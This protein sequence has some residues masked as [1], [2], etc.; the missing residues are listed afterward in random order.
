MTYSKYAFYLNR[1]GRDAGFEDKL[2]SYCFRRGCANAIDGKASDA[3][4]D[5]VMRHNPF[6]GV[7]NEAYNNQAVRFNVQDAYLE[8]DITDD[9]LTRAFTHMSIRCNPGAPK[10]VPRE[11]M[12]RLLAADPEIVVLEREI[13][14]SHTRIKWDYTFINRA[15]KEVREAHKKLGQQLKAA[16]KS[17]E[18]ELEAEH[19][20]DYFYYIYNEMM[21]RQLNRPLNKTVVEAEPVIE[22]QLEE[23]TRLQL[24]LC[25]LSKNLSSQA[26]V[27]RKVCA[28]NLEI[29][30]AS[31]KEL[32][33]RQ[34][35][36]APACKD[37]LREESSVPA[38]ALTPALDP[39]PPAMKGP[40]PYALSS[41]QAAP[42]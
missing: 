29:A 8:S 12:D 13:K 1:L 20:K 9:G 31:R 25:D 28:I 41:L 35:P 42:V 2:T 14:E 36:S 21:K 6:T 23:R 34:P 15:P 27:A 26:I 37:P 7:F 5:Q 40:Y 19:R 4:R 18:D 10:E 30:L 17:L 39:L 38:P 33:T 3:V 24:V 32:M 16:T 11:V 22:H